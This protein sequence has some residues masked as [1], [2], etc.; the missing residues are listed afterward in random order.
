MGTAKTGVRNRSVVA[1][2]VVFAAYNALMV[3]P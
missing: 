3:L 1:L 2:V